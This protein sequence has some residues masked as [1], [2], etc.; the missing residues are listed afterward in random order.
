MLA[1][2]STP[3]GYRFENETLVNIA[4]LVLRSLHRPQTQPDTPPHR[5]G[6]P[7]RSPWQ[8]RPAAGC[9]PGGGPAPTPAGAAD[10]TGSSFNIKTAFHGYGDSH[11]KDKTV[12]RPSYL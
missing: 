1:I 12:M 9:P 4:Y 3:T 10:R 11:V 7:P 2:A 8:S 6:A 5:F